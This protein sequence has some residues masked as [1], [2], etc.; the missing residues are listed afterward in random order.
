MTLDFDAAVVGIASQPFWLCW[1]DEGGRRVSHAPDFFARRRDGSAVVID[2]RP[3]ERRTARDMAKFDATARACALAAFRRRSFAP[4][5]S[6]IR[7]T[8]R[9]GGRFFR[10]SANASRSL[11]M[12]N[13]AA[14]HRVRRSW[15]SRGR[16]HR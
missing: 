16:Q 2:C 15:S 13:G 8:Y 6:S 9:R 12:T 10:W 1:A 3:V 11:S 5:T 7:R 14:G 4:R